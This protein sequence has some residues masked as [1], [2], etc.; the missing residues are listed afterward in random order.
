MGLFGIDATENEILN[1]INGD[2][3]KSSVSLGGGKAHGRA[4]IDITSDLLN[5]NETEKDQYM[6]IEVID[7]SNA[8]EYYETIYAK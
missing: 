1:I 5:G 3:Q 4:L 7:A 2:P 8:E 6:P